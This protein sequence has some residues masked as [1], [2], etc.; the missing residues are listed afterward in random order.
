MVELVNSVD[1]YQTM[2]FGIGKVWWLFHQE[3]LS[4]SL[5]SIGSYCCNESQGAF[6]LSTTGPIKIVNIGVS[7]E[8]YAVD[9]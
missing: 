8:S 3:I 1:T 5:I 4:Q 9:K 2:P 6:S 7:S